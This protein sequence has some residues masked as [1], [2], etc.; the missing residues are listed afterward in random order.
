MQKYVLKLRLSVHLICEKRKLLCEA[1][2]PKFYNFL[3]IKHTYINIQKKKGNLR[4][5][6]RL[7]TNV[8]DILTNILIASMLHLE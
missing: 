5:L 4:L 1:Q 2:S 7:C 8:H 6:N 3:N